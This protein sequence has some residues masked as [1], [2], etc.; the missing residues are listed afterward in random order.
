ML[1]FC[2]TFLSWVL[3]LLISIPSVGQ[4]L[5]PDGWPIPDLKGLSPYSITI[6]KVDGVEKMVEKFYTLSGGHVARVSGNGRVYAYV[7]DS[8]QEPPIDYLLLDPGGSGKF[9]TK[10]GPEGLFV[11]PEWVSR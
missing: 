2:V 8:D 5:N 4:E 1:R 7:I 3:F 6:T 11:I 9:T 10:M